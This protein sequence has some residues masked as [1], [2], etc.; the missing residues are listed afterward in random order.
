MLY[1]I[2][3]FILRDEKLFFVVLV[4]PDV[5]SDHTQWLIDVPSRIPAVQGSCVV[6]P[7]TYAYP[8]PKSKAIL[9]RWRGFWK[10]GTKIVSTNLHKWKLTEEFK[11]RTQLLGNL[12]A[13][14]CTMFL[15]GV[16]S[17]DVGPFYFRIEMPQYNSFSFTEKTVSID[18]IREYWR[19]DILM[20]SKHLL[21]V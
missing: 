6:I 8:K 9:N 1:R 7:C 3:H 16:R 4:I 17:T 12:R 18:V 5:Q 10:R 15:D 19:E 20:I 11:K 13:R 14:N 2:Y 21:S